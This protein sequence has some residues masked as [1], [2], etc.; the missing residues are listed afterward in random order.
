MKHSPS[1]CTRIRVF[2]RC[3]VAVV[4]NRQ[5]LPNIRCQGSKS[6]PGP[7]RHSFN[8]NFLI[9]LVLYIYQFQ[10]WILQLSSFPILSFQTRSIK[11]GV[12]TQDTCP[13]YFCERKLL[14][15]SLINHL[16]GIFLGF[17]LLSSR[18]NTPLECA[19][20]KL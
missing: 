5:Y 3:V 9:S 2:A 7:P 10:L 15:S 11:H 18:I 16:I 12:Q 1:Y 8:V 6:F 20:I 4:L 19:D 14:L 17:K 13:Q